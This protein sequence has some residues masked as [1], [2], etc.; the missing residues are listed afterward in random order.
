MDWGR[1]LYERVRASHEACGA[2]I[3]A[4]DEF[5]GEDGWQYFPLGLD[6]VCGIKHCPD[7]DG[8][9]FVIALPSVPCRRANLRALAIMRDHLGTG[10]CLYTMAWKNHLLAL[11]INQKMGGE[12]LGFDTDGYYHFKHTRDSLRLPKALR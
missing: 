4:F 8:D 5:A 2:P 10:R 6:G 3:E 1:L 12:L 11:H 9:A 7:K